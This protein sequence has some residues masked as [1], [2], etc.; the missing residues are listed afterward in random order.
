[1]DVTQAVEKVNFVVSAQVGIAILQALD[2]H[3]TFDPVK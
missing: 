2:G 3:F 1:V